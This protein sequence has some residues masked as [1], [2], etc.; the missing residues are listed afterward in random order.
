MLLCIIYVR[1]LFVVLLHDGRR[2]VKYAHYDAFHNGVGLVLRQAHAQAVVDVWH[3]EPLYRVVHD[4]GHESYVFDAEASFVNAL[5]QH[6]LQ[7]AVLFYVKSFAHLF[8]H[9]DVAEELCAQCA[10][11]CHGVAYMLRWV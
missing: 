5:L 2:H 7:D 3:F 1:I 10:V 9:P 4:V 6:L 11:A 8:Y